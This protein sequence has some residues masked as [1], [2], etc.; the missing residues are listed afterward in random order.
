MHHTALP[1]RNLGLP[2]DCVTHCHRPLAGGRQLMA[3]RSSV[4][5]EAGR[6]VTGYQAVNNLSHRHTAVGFLC[7]CPVTEQESWSSARLHNAS[8]AGLIGRPVTRCPKKMIP[9][10]L[11]G[12]FSLHYVSLPS[13][14]LGFPPG[15]VTHQPPTLSA[16]TERKSGTS[17]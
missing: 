10:A 9:P 4:I 12:G 15:C 17:A 3:L 16:V 14:N 7:S 8:A 6:P 11:P 2:P 5:D 1:S 13:R